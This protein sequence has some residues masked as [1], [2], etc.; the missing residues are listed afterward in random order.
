MYIGPFLHFFFFKY[1]INNGFVLCQSVIGISTWMFIYHYSYLTYNLKDINGWCEN[2]FKIRNGRWHPGCCILKVDLQNAQIKTDIKQKC[3]PWA[4]LSYIHS[5]WMH[6]YCRYTQTHLC[7]KTDSC[8]INETIVPR[9]V[10][11]RTT[12]LQWDVA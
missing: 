2:R 8:V 9:A 6:S 3:V 10:W 7:I 1:Y 12:Q 4:A 5:H 11:R